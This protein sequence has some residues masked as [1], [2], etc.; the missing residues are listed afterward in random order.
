MNRISRNLAIIYRTERLITRRRL[1]VIQQQTVLMALAGVA[2]LAGL[3]LLNIT[4][5]LVLSTWV[6]PAVAAGILT[7]ANLVLAALLALVA[8]RTN[9]EKEIA[10][11]V[12]VRD[13]AIADIEDELEGMAVETR[14]LVNSVRKLSA[15]PLGALS[16]LLVPIVTAAMKKKGDKVSGS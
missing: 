4:L 3:I 8:G 9:I 1:A 6:S 10:P 7:V 11:A 14:E 5:Y 16:T 15:N 12:E 2:A 13:M